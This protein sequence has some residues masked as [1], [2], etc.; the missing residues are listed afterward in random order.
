MAGYKIFF[1]KSV[2]KDFKV[3]PDK[4][5]NKILQSIESLGEDPRQPGSNKLSAQEKYR[6]RV[7]R[8]RII[9]SIQEE[10][11]TIWV[12]KVGH[13]KDIYR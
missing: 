1:K 11:L 10:E 12:V 2:W 9:Y 6:F 5:L 7:G 13:R 8:Y 4:D 3:I